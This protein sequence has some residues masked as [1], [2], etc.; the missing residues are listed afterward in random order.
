MRPPGSRCRDFELE[1]D[2][3]FVFEGCLL[4]QA[5]GKEL[6]WRQDH[7]QEVL[8]VN[9]GGLLA[10]TRPLTVGTEER[11]RMEECLDGRIQGSHNGLWRGKGG[12]EESGA[13]E[14]LPQTAGRKGCQARMWGPVGWSRKR[15]D[16][17][18]GSIL[19]VSGLRGF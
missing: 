14:V 15:G 11:G 19:D 6:G 9:Q 3:L 1:S 4:V 5:H 13:S 10:W 7:Q 2:T 8:T 16:E 17:L 18:V 12:A